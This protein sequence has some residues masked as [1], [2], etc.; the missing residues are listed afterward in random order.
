MLFLSQK[1]KF[2]NLC[3]LPDIFDTS[4]P[5]FDCLER[6]HKFTRNSYKEILIRVPS[7]YKRAKLGK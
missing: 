3:Y 6:L 7:V 4:E 5:L 1:S 2:H